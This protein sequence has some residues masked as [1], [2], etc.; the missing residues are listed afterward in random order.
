MY[1]L[2]T[3]RLKPRRDITGTGPMGV[4]LATLATFCWLGVSPRDFPCSR[5][6]G[7]V[8]AGTPS[9]SHGGAC[10]TVSD[11]VGGLFVLIVPC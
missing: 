3:R 11:A 2:Q 9:G 8:E 1:I 4:T 6:G 5:V 7:C 10:H